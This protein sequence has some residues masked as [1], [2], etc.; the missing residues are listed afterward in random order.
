MRLKQLSYPF[1]VMPVE[2]RRALLP[3]R[4]VCSLAPAEDPADCLYTGNGSH[5]LD[6]SGHPFRDAVTA[7]MELLQEPKWRTTPLPPDLRPYLADIRRALLAGRPE[8]AD[9]LLDQA[10][11]E[12]GHDKYIDLDKKIVYPIESLR[13]H[14]AFRLTLRRPETE[15]RD[16][17]RWLDMDTGKLTTHWESEGA[18]WE[19]EYLCLREGDFVALRLRAPAGRLEAGVEIRFPGGPGPFGRVS[20]ANALHQVRRSERGITAAWQYDPALCDNRG[21]I[22]VFRFL[23]RGGEIT[24]TPEGIQ[25]TGGDSLTL[26][27]KAIRYETGFSFTR[28]EEAERALDLPGD[29]DAW[30]ERN[31]AFFTERMDRSRLRLG[32]ESDHWL[33]G[34]ELLRAAHTGDRAREVLLEKLYDLGRFYQIM[35][36]GKLP[37][38]WG[39]HNINTNLQVCA[40]NNTGLFEEMDVYFRY[41][42]RKFDDFRVNARRLFGA[43]GLLASVHCDYDSGLL[44]H[45]SRTYPHYCWTGCLGWIYN[46]FWGYWL[47][48]GDRDFLRDRVVPALKEIALFYEDYACDRD[49]DGKAIFYPSFS[50]E[51]PT[52]NPDYAT[53][54]GR[55]RHPTRIN[56]VMDI[57][58]C[59]EVLTNLLT[60]CRTLGI[61]AENYPRW[62]KQLEDLPTLLLDADGGLRE[63]A[64]ESMEENYNHRHVSHHYDV[65]PGRAV[66]PETE[67]ELAEAIR[68]S[69]RKRGQQDDSAHGIIHRAFTAIRLKDAEEL[70]QNLSQLLEHGFVRRCLSTAHFPYKGQFPDLQGAMPALLLEMCVF[71]APGTVEFLPALPAWLKA[72]RLDG[73]WLYTWVKLESLEWDEMR[74]LAE[75]TPLEDQVLTLRCRFGFREFRV[76]GKARKPEGDHITLS[77]KA[78]ERL[79]A[80]VLR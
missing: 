50:P 62:E 63:W 19:N 43:R 31:R 37:P 11:R 71:S 64:W 61:E 10:Q 58:I 23:P 25:I 77:V 46:E 14:E 36:T 32:G 18:V 53:V 56:A 42:E 9:A 26:L 30:E 16:Y 22:L 74:I 72:G 7:N 24:L 41:Y 40:G 51:N 45:T 13:A 8:E 3:E 38:M 49:G 48:T 52:P 67:P 33:S 2:K 65:W 6:V 47:C 27:A 70:E 39:Q 69:N 76:N 59:R 55:D 34:E 17:L 4:S 15:V 66:T 79:T 54:T 60:A 29:F 78:G 28:M 44:Y 68:I 57:A 80:E 73:A 12:A 75:L 5:R 35:D 20:L 1:P 21:F